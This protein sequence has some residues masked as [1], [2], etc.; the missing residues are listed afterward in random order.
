MFH[1]YN[2]NKY[3]SNPIPKDMTLYTRAKGFVPRNKI[4][5]Y[6]KKKKIITNKK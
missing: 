5:K 2:W 6:L 1:E 3:L 4:H